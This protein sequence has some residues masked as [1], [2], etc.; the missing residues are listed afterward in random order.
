MEN[1]PTPTPAPLSVPPTLLRVRYV[2]V[3]A[4]GYVYHSNYF[5]YFEQ[6]RTEA[7]RWTGTPYTAY[8]THGV[9]MP[10]RSMGI[11]FRRPARYDD[12]LAICALVEQLTPVRMRI[13]YRAYVITERVAALACAGFTA[14]VF[15]DMT[16]KPTR[17]SRVPAVWESVQK[18]AAATAYADLVALGLA[19]EVV[20]GR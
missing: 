8:E 11:E 19:D 13:A 1:A 6:A 7:A 15:T 17:A 4:F 10:L 16:G 18:I 5:P 2:E 14:H 12:Q 9:A 3:D 20:E